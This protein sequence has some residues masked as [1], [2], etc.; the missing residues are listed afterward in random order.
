M[1]YIHDIIYKIPICLSVSHIYNVVRKHITKID[2][3]RP[4]R[5]NIISRCVYIIN[6]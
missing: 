5:K 3:A 1:I 4:V 6:M 2:N